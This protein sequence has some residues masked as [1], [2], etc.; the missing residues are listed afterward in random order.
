MDPVTRLRARSSLGEVHGKWVIGIL[1]N[2]K[3]SGGLLGRENSSWSLEV[4][5]KKEALSHSFYSPWF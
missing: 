4:L 2:V 3:H 5:F 1:P